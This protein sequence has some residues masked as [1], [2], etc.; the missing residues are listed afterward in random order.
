MNKSGAVKLFN[1]IIVKN[2]QMEHI[3]KYMN[4]ALFNCMYEISPCRIV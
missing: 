2:L 3:L 4:I 1:T